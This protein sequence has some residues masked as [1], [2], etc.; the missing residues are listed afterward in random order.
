MKRQ[1]CYLLQ[2][3]GGKYYFRMSVPEK[4]RPVLRKRELKQPIIGQDPD[5]ARETAIQLAAS[6]KHVFTKIR[7]CMTQQKKPPT[8]QLII[9]GLIADHKT[10]T[11]QAP[12]D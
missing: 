10:G 3:P 5:Y 1:P 9:S 12:T 4:L 7:D 6:W 8:L 2:R 11:V